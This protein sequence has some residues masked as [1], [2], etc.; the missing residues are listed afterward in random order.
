MARWLLA[1]CLAA[2]LAT[3]HGA[4][5]P[6]LADDPAQAE[7]FENVMCAE[8]FAK[9]TE[10]FAA[11]GNFSSS[12]VTDMT[13]WLQVIPSILRFFSLD[14]LCLSRQFHYAP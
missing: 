12:L 2:G 7:W 11:P 10:T 13:Q 14:I 4:E 6:A 9:S 8:A 3:A 1:F 5:A